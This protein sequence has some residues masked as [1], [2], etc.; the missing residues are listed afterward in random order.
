MYRN[1]FGQARLLAVLALLLTVSVSASGQ[2]TTIAA[3]VTAAAGQAAQDASLVRKLSIDEAV[4]QALEQ[5]LSIQVERLD[6]Q[7]QDLSIAQAYTAWTPTFSMGLDNNWA[8]TPPTSS[9]SG[10]DNIIQS[11]TLSSSLQWN[12]NLRWRG[13]TYQVFWDSSRN[14]S[15][16][17]FNDFNPLLRTNFN[18]FLQQPLL[19]RNFS[20]DPSRQQLIISRKNREISDIQLRDVVVTTLRAVKNAYWEL[21]FARANLTSQQQSLEL[22]Q[23]TL[24]DNRTR[25]EVGTMAPIDIVEA[26]AEVARNEE[27][28]IVAEAAI[29]EAEDQLRALAF[30]P[31]TPDFWRLRIETTDLP[32]PKPMAIDPDAALRSALDKRTDLQQTRKNLEAT[33]L[34]IRYYRNQRLPQLNFEARY[35]PSA[36]GGTFL[37]REPGFPP[38]P[39]LGETQRSYW[40]ALGD[41]LGGDFPSWTVGVT[42]S[43]PIGSSSSDVLLARSRLEYT[44]SQAQLR[45]QELQVGTQ[46]RDVARQVNTNQKRV[47]ATQSARQLAE[48]RLE[49]EQK[50]FGVGLSTNFQ[51]FQAQ[52]DLTTA[53]NNEL[54]AILDFAKAQVDFEA[55]QEVSVSTTGNVV[56]TGSAGTGQ[57][58]AT[59]STLG[60]TSGTNTTGTNGTTGGTQNP[61]Q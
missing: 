55:V 20:V 58:A 3:Q 43:Y 4:K 59:S 52:R 57:T 56:I 34:N 19:L 35:T 6:P 21:V 48:R 26:E 13:G 54:R 7:L 23:Q 39:V 32:D 53:R 37:E 24:K 22:A 40:S 38:G 44:R 47:E 41:T 49:A 17:L 5:N 42:L 36:I 45:N 15:N 1:P 60:Q 25:V 51:V 8:D 46:V 12:Q 30:D 14:T 33:D 31:A 29:Q 28:V 2:T 10:A 18:M 11:D 50:K 9:L 16:N 61:P 27:T